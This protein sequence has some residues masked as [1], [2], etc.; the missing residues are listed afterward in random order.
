MSW[1]KSKWPFVIFILLSLCVFILTIYDTIFY[2]EWKIFLIASYIVLVVLIIIT[3]IIRRKKPLR[4]I[5]SIEEFEK[6]LK[7][8]LYH[9]KCPICNGI[10]AVKKSKSN[11]K[12]P[13]KMNCPDC[14]SFGFIPPNPV[15]I[16]DDIP[17]KKSIKA[18]FRCIE[19]GEGI[20]VWAEGKDL[21]DNVIVYSCPF[22][23]VEKKLD[24]F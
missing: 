1:I 9:F 11:D 15:C 10:F 7:G 13:V 14:G 8:R 22:C 3:I 2:M 21:Y 18:N 16:K 24:R 12:R 6:S 4:Q 20:T 17:E 23:G 19:C 5:G